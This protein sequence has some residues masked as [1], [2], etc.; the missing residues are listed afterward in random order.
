MNAS[1]AASSAA[2]PAAALDAGAF[3]TRYPELAVWCMG[4]VKSSVIVLMVLALAAL[5]RGRS[6]V[7]RCWIL[8]LAFPALLLTALWPLA[9]GRLPVLSVHV[10]APAASGWETVQPDIPAVPPQPAMKETLI[11]QMD[12]PADSVVPRVLP[13]IPEMDV[14]EAF[15]EPAPSSQS[16]TDEVPSWK[17][18]LKELEDH[19]LFLWSGGAMLVALWLV[20]RNVTGLFWLH[21]HGQPADG[22]MTDVGDRL[23]DALRMRRANYRR[24]PGLASPLL[25]G[26]FRARL[27]LP[28][29]MSAMT[30]AQV[31]AIL[32]HELAHHRRRDLWWQALA[33]CA[34]AIW[35]WNPA[36]WNLGKRLRHE[37]ELAADDAVVTGGGAAADYAELLVRVASGWTVGDARAVRRTG[38]PMM[39]S[40]AIERRV[41]A[42]LAESPFRNRMG[43]TAGA[44]VAFIAIM[45]AGIASLTAVARPVESPLAMVADMEESEGDS[46]GVDPE[47]ELSRDP[48]ADRE[49]LE[50]LV[51][52]KNV[53]PDYLHPP[54]TDIGNLVELL[55]SRPMDLKDLDDL[56][57]LMSEGYINGRYVGPDEGKPN[58]QIARVI[59]QDRPL[60]TEARIRF[61]HART[62]Q[63]MPGL[64]FHLGFD[65]DLPFQVAADG[66]GRY[67]FTLSPETLER[68]SRPERIMW[69]GTKRLG[70]LVAEA[71]Y[72]MKHMEFQRHAWGQEIEVRMEPSLPISGRV[73][74]EDGQPVAG[75][76]IRT[77]RSPFVHPMLILLPR[78]FGTKTDDDGRWS[79]DG[80]PEDL[81]KLELDISHPDYVAFSG[82]ATDLPGGEE[83]LR[84]GSSTL[85]LKT[86][87]RIHGRVVDR[88]GRPVHG[89][90]INPRAISSPR[91]A[92][93]DGDGRFVIKRLPGK[94]ALL[95]I[96]ADGFSPSQEGV[97]VGQEKDH[98]F[99]LSPP[100]LFR[101]RVVREDERPYAG[102]EV[103]VDQWRN[104]RTL[105]YRTQTDED[106]RFT[107]DSAPAEPFTLNIGEGERIMSG[108]PIAG[109]GGEVVIVMKPAL[110]IK[111]TAVDDAT[112]EPVRNFR[113]T[114]VS[115][116]PWVYRDTLA[117]VKGKLEWETYKFEK[118][119]INFRV[120]ADGFDPLVTEVHPT[121]QQKV[122]AVWRLKR[123]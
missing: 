48:A 71:G 32:R 11:K 7:A 23:T 90:R 49:M 120:E 82:S 50:R 10:D 33:S 113:V 54:G 24:V 66:D 112:A 75:A 25:T 12:P 99:T 103:R 83:V 110:R 37:T 108:Y 43:W 6:A 2:F 60:P 15:P 96:E 16:P 36:V 118:N 111:V 52:P 86:G 73:V 92:I 69:A 87:P 28:E 104:Q 42:I 102:V 74:G 115:A 80:F 78:N 77:D 106:G 51:S 57:H 76:A 64:R 91:F 81:S 109:P 62:G 114:P 95:T 5:F 59:P 121:R 55:H 27:W 22:T 89:A 61:I 20:F 40:S 79:L 3:L 107:W 38:V 101:G 117:S 68:E 122:E 85:V 100:T 44:A 94:Y 63:P 53:P 29:G 93:T 67:I 26:W 30:E 17:V 88:D 105:G 1:G 45:G 39:G 58:I 84:N 18:A 97:M 8:R 56:Q 41:R 70:I 65:G 34:C 21:R 98:V 72:L 46:G 13:V 116:N 119:G 14:A 35:W 31:R 19:L 4:A 47:G 9:A 123:K